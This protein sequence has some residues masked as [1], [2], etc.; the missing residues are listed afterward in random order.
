MNVEI[1]MAWLR[2][3]RNLGGT[4]EAAGATQASRTTDRPARPVYSAPTDTTPQLTRRASL[5]TSPIGFRA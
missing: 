3:L 4:V 5:R 2:A 1:E